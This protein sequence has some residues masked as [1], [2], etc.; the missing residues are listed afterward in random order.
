MWRG[1]GCGSVGAVICIDACG[2]EKRE[3]EII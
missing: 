3:R 1:G 2:C